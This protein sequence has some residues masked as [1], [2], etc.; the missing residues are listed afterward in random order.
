MAQNPM[1]PKSQ[2]I[3][4]K[5]QKNKSASD[6]TPADIVHSKYCIYLLSYLL[7]YFWDLQLIC[8]NR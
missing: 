6:S 3:V 4:L 8:C 1:F 5:I 2:T 7:I